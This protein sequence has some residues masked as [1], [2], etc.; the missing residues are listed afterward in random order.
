MRLGAGPWGVP[1]RSG[2]PMSWTARAEGS[3][4]VGAAGGA[5]RPPGWVAGLDATRGL[6]LIGLICVDVL[7]QA[8]RG[9][10]GASWVSLVLPGSAAA[11]VALLAGVGLALGCGGRFPHEGRWLAAD[12]L[13]TAVRAVLVGGV[14][15]GAGALLPEDVPAGEILVCYGLLCLLAIPFLHLSARALFLG[16][17]VCWVV[18]PLLVAALRALLPAATSSTAVAG[19]LE[20]PAGAVAPLLLTGTSPALPYLACLLAGLGLGRVRLRD[21][22]IQLRLLAVG[23]VLVVTAPHIGRPL[24]TVAAGLGAGLLVLGGCLLLSRG[25]GA[26]A[27]PLSAM[28]AMGLTLYTTHLVMLSVGLRTDPSFP[29]YLLHPVVAALLAL[30]W[31]RALGRGPLERAVEASVHATRRAVLRRSH[32]T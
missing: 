17:A 30:H 15:L 1:G 27:L 19:V 23:A 3:A 2:E 14:G 26:W 31:R 32:R 5:P 13:G 7:P 18:G 11:L 29:W 16:A 21:R 20:E 28:G 8:V 10:H 4:P 25:S 9:A 24:G 12:R 6:V 22:G